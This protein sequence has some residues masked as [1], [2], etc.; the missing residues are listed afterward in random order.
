MSLFYHYRI[1]SLIYSI[2]ILSLSLLYHYSIIIEFYHYYTPLK[3]CHIPLCEASQKWFQ[4]DPA[5]TKAGP[6]TVHLNVNVLYVLIAAKA[7]DHKNF[8]A[9][10]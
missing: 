1:L 3:F 9:R 6:E 7:Y 4:S 8:L 10:V 5:L 2:I